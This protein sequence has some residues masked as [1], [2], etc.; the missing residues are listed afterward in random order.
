M[1]GSGLGGSADACGLR[2]SSPS[3]R[4]SLD[5]GPSR[6]SRPAARRIEAYAVALKLIHSILTELLPFSRARDCL[7]TL[8]HSGGDD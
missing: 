3:D 6:G 2:V 7:Q 5:S 1:S 4:K 8:K